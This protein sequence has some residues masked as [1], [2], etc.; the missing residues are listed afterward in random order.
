MKNL[1]IASQLPLLATLSMV[2]IATTPA[3]AAVNTLAN[4]GSDGRLAQNRPESTYTLGA[5]DRI[6]VDIFNVPEYSGEFQ[7]LVDGTLNLPII[8]TV[9][10]Q[11]GTIPQVSAIVQNR[12][13]RYVRRPIVTISLLAPRPLQIALPIFAN[14]RRSAKPSNKQAASVS[15]RIYAECRFGDSFPARVIAFLPPMY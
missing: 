13:A 5:G 8:G 2:A 3:N 9:P 14:F 7:V 15:R 11:N 10:V 12:Y 6:R 1:P 4:G